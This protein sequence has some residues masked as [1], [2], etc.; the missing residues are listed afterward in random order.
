M[1]F[2]FTKSEVKKKKW[3]LQYL[4]MGS[5]LKTFLCKYVH[6]IWKILFFEIKYFFYER[7]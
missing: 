4:L 7:E 5:H 1:I 3:Y 2:C 6:H